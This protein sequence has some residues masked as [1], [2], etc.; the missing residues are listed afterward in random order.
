MD[1]V[2]TENYDMIQSLHY[3]AAQKNDL[4]AKTLKP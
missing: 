3:S 4:I 1:F 2:Q